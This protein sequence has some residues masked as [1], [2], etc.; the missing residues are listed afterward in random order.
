MHVAGLDRGVLNRAATKCY[1]Q[2][3]VTYLDKSNQKRYKGRQHL[4]TTQ[5]LV[6]TEHCGQLLDLN[7]SSGKVKAAEDVSSS[8]CQRGRSRD[9]I[10]DYYSFLKGDTRSLDYSLYGS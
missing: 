5:S 6:S 7:K 1:L 10:G 9:F 2:T 3:A 4:E 8:I